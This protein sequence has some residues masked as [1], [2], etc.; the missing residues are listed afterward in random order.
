MA[1]TKE[2]IFHAADQLAESGESPTLA[3]V[4]KA[5]GGGSFTTIS[6]AMNEWKAKQ[7]ATTTPMREP[8]P[9]A[10]TSRLDEIGA[11]IWAVALDK[12]NA[13]LSSEREALEATRVQLETAQQEATELADQLSV[14]LETLQAQHLQATQDLQAASTTIETLRQEN[15]SKSRQLATT[16]A[17]AEETTKRADDLK[18]ELQHAHAENT[19][20]RQR[21]TQ[22]TQALQERHT[23]EVQAL[24][25][26]L[27][28]TSDTLKT[29]TAEAVRLQAQ[30]D[31]AQTQLASLHQQQQVDQERHAREIQ[32]LGERL[33][34]AQAEKEQVLQAASTS[35]EDAAGLRGELEALRVQNAAL[36]ATLT[37]AAPDT[38]KSSKAKP[39]N[40]Q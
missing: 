27:S 3:N 22:E 40:K 21:H 38:P 32:Q 28:H 13:R 36:L 9:E 18:A 31:Q 8:A 7:Q 30:L 15:A 1:L 6:E 29:Q 39:T 11:E 12:A 4:R 37:P 24:Q 34:K 35:R 33:D 20:Q 19:A 25:T 2:Q 5:L 14:E 16:E 26:N 23:S 17:R 10:I